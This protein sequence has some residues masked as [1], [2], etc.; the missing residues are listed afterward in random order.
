MYFFMLGKFPSILTILNAFIMKGIL[1][2]AFSVLTEMI[3]WFFLFVIL[4][5]C[6]TV[7]DF[8]VLNNVWISG[9]N[10]IWLWCTIILTCGW[11]R[12]ASIL[13]ENFYMYIDKI[14]WAVNFLVMYL[15]GFDIMVM[16]VSQ[17]E[18]GSVPY[19]FTYLEEFEKEWC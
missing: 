15:S 19:L 2:N 6:I 8:I 9:T 5:W 14:K 16:L 3:I 1:L 17:N 18:L 12:V 4:M 7:I 11:I 10:S 13:W